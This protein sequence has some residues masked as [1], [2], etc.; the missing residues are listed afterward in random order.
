MKILVNDCEVE[1]KHI[2]SKLG[3]IHHDEL[4]HLAGYDSKLQS[5]TVAWRSELDHAWH[6]LE[7]NAALWIVEGSRVT[8]RPIIGENREISFEHVKG[9]AFHNER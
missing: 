8:V 7:P 1:L 5:F 2:T 4:I 3:L 6:V 9:A